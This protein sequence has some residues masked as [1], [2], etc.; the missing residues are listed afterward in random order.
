MGKKRDLKGLPDNLVQRYFSSLFYWESGYMP[1]WIWY[2]AEE[3]GVSDIEIDILK[4]SVVPKELEIKPIIVH[5]PQLEKTINKTLESNGFPAGF[6]VEAKISIYISQKHKALKLLSGTGKLKDVDGKN[7]EGNPFT[8]RAYEKP[9]NLFP[10]TI[11][12]QEDYVTALKES[13]N[14]KWWGFWKKIN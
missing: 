4:R 1:D 12:E 11:Q 3:K 13:R 14:R 7:Y 9:F 10:K 8:E 2:A 6:I 5:L